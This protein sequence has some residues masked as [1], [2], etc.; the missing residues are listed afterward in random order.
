MEFE[1]M[2]KIWSMQNN[3][4]LYVINEKALHS[5]ILSKKKSAS[6]IVNFSEL[7]GIVVNIGTS[8]FVFGV[9]LSKPGTHIFIYLMAAWMMITALYLLVSR[10]Q[11]QKSENRFD[12][13][14]LGDLDHAIYN[15]SY[16]VRRSRLMLWNVLPI[17]LLILFSFWESGKLSV[18]IALAMLI[19]FVLVFYAGSWEHSIYIK[20]KRVL[21]VLRKKLIG[22]ETTNDHSSLL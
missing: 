21:E 15:A 2:Q 11:R 10:I 5:R 22:E 1:E 6:H 18:W 9:A 20:K 17:T 7:L 16:Q 19:F 8:L 12:R 14:L 3:E 13:S 4:A